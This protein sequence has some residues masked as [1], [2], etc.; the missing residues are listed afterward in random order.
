MYEY[1]ISKNL[2][3]LLSKL[4]KRDKKLYQNLVN[5]MHEIIQSQSFDHYKN[6]KHHLKEYK[7]VHIG[8]FVL[9][10]RFDKE[11]NFVLFQDFDHHDCIYL[12]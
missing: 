12:K 6:L 11:Q 2:E 7:R 10:F 1:K 5:K 8:S 3:R 4:E 9:T